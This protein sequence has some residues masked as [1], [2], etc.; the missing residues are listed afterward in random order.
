MQVSPSKD[1][2]AYIKH[3]LFLTTT[4]QEVKKLRL[5]SDGNTGMVFSF[6]DRL[7]S[8]FTA[9]GTPCYLPDSFIYGQLNSFKDLYCI[10]QT[11]LMI[12][13]FHP[14]GLSNLLAIPSDELKNKSI[15]TD[16]LLGSKAA[17]LYEKMFESSTIQHMISLAEDFF[18]EIIA[19]KNQAVPS[20]IT[21]AVNFIAQNKG[22]LPVSNLAVLTGHNERKLERTFIEFIG[23]SPKRFSNIIKL[24]VFLK[25]LRDRSVQDNLA[26]FGYEAGYYDQPHLI[27]E[28]KKYTG[29]TPRQYT[30][31]T[32]PLAINFLEC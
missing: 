18:R 8:G 4:N 26:S 28:F 20:L 30:S 31:I 19:A 10:G 1:L 25:H 11:A 13:V 15:K 24:H 22:L 21:A 12:V 16:E 32:D 29:L 14:H 17:E 5:F 23:I 27:R 6:K 2:S 7:I 9:L 3:Y